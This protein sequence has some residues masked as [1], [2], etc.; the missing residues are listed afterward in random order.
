M[1]NEMEI[2]EVVKITRKLTVLASEPSKEFEFLDYVVT[3]PHGGSANRYLG[4]VVQIRKNGKFGEIVFLRHPDGTLTPHENNCF[5]KVPELLLEFMPDIFKEC[6]V[7][8]S[9]DAAY[10]GLDQVG[11]TGFIID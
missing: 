8:D 10:C 2:I 5:W 4:R 6:R 3:G 7:E 11:K 1:E 9:T